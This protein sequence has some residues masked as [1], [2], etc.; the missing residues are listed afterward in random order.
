MARDFINIEPRYREPE[1]QK[2]QST[3][4]DWL[5]DNARLIIG[6]FVVLI[7]FILF[8]IWWTRDD[9]LDKPPAPVAAH[10][11]APPPIQQPIGQVPVQ[12]PVAPPVTHPPVASP[13]PQPAPRQAARPVPAPVPKKEPEH[14][15]DPEVYLDL[16]QKSKKAVDVVIEIDPITPIETI[17]EPQEDM[18][19]QYGPCTAI[20]TNGNRCKKKAITD[21]RCNLHQHR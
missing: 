12:Q 19:K 18:P 9:P 14:I 17:P 4:Q 10:P 13:D 15:E 1:I 6:A 5:V 8:Y 11:T 2:A 16:L 3:A 21:G 7:L 20:M